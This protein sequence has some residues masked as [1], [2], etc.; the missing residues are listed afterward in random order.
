[1]NAASKTGIFNYLFI[2]AIIKCFEKKLLIMQK[3][4][5]GER[6]VRMLTDLCT[7]E[8]A[9]KLPVH[10][11]PTERR[12]RRKKE[13]KEKKKDIW[14]MKYIIIGLWSFEILQPLRILKKI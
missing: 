7:W 13:K 14:L 12:I 8:S 9:L 2:E 3:W 4:S 5:F 11:P 1:M 10:F 6:K